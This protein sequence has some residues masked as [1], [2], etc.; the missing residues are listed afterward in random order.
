IPRLIGHGVVAPVLALVGADV[1]IGAGL[2]VRR[3]VGVLPHG[4]DP[5][6]QAV[7]LE[8]IVEPI[9]R[10]GAEASQRC[11]VLPAAQS[12]P[13]GAEALRFGGWPCSPGVHDDVALTAVERAEL[14]GVAGLAGVG[15]AL[16][17]S[18]HGDPPDCRGSPGEVGGE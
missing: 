3:G 6:V 14:A 17:R 1:E 15:L 18:R 2:T 11:L 4:V 10:G 5:G 9:D 7:S 8:L 12:L 13:E 16:D